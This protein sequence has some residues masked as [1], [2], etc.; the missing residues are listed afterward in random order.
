MPSYEP[1]NYGPQDD[2]FINFDG[3]RFLDSAP[4][5]GHEPT[6][7]V[8]GSV[9]VIEHVDLIEELVKARGNIHLAAERT[10]L[11][12]TTLLSAA[13]NNMP[14]L[15]KELK[16]RVLLDV[17]S[18]TDD[19][20]LQLKQS[21]HRLDPADIGKTYT[22]LLQILSV[23][24]DDK[25]STVNMNVQEVIYSLLPPDIREAVVELKQRDQ[26]LALAQISQANSS[27]LRVVGDDE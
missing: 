13:A 25:T 7:P 9:Q 10:G 20:K 15:Q 26:D 2:P 22:T 14:R 5:N 8:N 12:H 23:L 17:F 4:N 11:S 1:P 6:P 19:V 21:L 27:N 18:I 3:E 16:A 24:T